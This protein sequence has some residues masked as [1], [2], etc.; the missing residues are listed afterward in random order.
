M[1]KMIQSRLLQQAGIIQATSTKYAGN[2]AFMQ[3]RNK[4]NQAQE[5]LNLFLG[6]LGLNGLDHVILYL[7]DVSHSNNVAI[8]TF[9]NTKGR[10]ILNQAHPSIISLHRHDLS[11][12]FKKAME[13]NDFNHLLPAINQGVDAGIS[14]VPNVFFGILHADCAPV[15]LYDPLTHFFAL[16]HAGTVGAINHIVSNTL[17]VMQRHCGVRPTNVLAYIGPCIAGEKYNITYSMYWPVIKEVIPEQEALNLDL[18]YMIKQELL[19]AKVQEKNIELSPF[20]TAD[21]ELFFSN[22]KTKDPLA[23]GR[24]I[25]IIGM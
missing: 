18:K 1:E 11:Y 3:S 22:H 16:I 14:C 21:N 19:K 4:N 10:N 20:C 25:T 15:C 8:A 17:Y 6:K 7:L 5:N 24:N 2:M 13:A 12:K 9:S 23:E